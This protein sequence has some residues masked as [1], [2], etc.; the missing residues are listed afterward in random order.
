MQTFQDPFVSLSP[1]FLYS[2]YLSVIMVLLHSLL[3]CVPQGLQMITH[4]R[5]QT[6]F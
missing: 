2:L 4:L 1:V 3:H 6:V 5:F